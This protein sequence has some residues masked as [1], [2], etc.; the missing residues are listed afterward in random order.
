[1]CGTLKYLIKFYVVA[2]GYS[3]SAMGAMMLEK[4][5]LFY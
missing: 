5:N 3:I 2:C 4:L 1:M